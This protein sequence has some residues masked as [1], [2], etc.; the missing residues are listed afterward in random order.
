MRALLAI[1]TA[2][3][4]GDDLFDQVST[5]E[6]LDLRDRAFM[7]ELVRGVLRYRATLDWRLGLL[8]DRRIAKLPTL[9]QTI[10]RL[11]AYQLLYLDRVPDSAAVNESV[12]MTKQQSRRLGRDWSGFVNAVLRALLRSPEP[13][14]PEA[15]SH[16]VEALAVRYS[17]PA[18]LVERWCRRLGAERAEALCRASVE[19]P[20][21]TL[22]VNTLRTS[23]AALLA[24]LAAAQ[25][26]AGPTSISEVGIQLA[27]SGSVIDLPGYAEGRFYVEDEAGQLIPLLLDVQPGQRVLDACAAP[28]GKATHMAA[29]MEN[30][31]EIVAVDRASARLDLVSANCRRL[32]VEILTPLAG[33][34]RALA[35]AGLAAHPMLSRP[36][37]RILLDAPC[38]G[39][40][41]LRRHPEGKWYKT[42]E[43]IAQHRQMQV[44]LLAVTSRLLRPGGVLVYSTCSIEPEETESIIDEFCQA[45]RQFQRES[46]APWLPPAGL[47]FV[48]P[49]GDLST[50]ANS[51]RMDLFFA[52]RVRRSE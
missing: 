25:V 50:M 35:G 15:G 34:L 6:V 28:G 22:R 13:A 41:V 27:R 51:N 4:L 32:G 10:L 14:W 31:G 1:D 11:G 39:L 19:V 3:M 33:N 52:A 5:R 8:S 18:W 49:R 36:F 48:T 45:H 9:I 24:D 40:G 21:L 2:G 16:P 23:R 43:S 37:D 26:E 42:L 30:Q 46:I 47:P 44:E 7:V 29:L 17:C 20:P 38:S 12:Q